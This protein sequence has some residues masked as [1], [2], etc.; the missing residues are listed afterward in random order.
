M[1]GSGFGAR[2]LGALD[3]SYAKVTT[4][5]MCVQPSARISNAVVEPYN[6][7]LHHGQQLMSAGGRNCVT[8]LFQNEAGYRVCQQKLGIEQPSYSHVNSVLAQVK[9]TFA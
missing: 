4:L 2:V 1:L 5:Q 8:F 9:G 6:A 3:T 7:I